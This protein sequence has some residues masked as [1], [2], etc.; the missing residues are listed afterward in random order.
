MSIQLCSL[1]YEHPD[2]TKIFGPLNLSLD[3][4][5]K[6]GLVGPNGVGKST[7]ARIIAGELEPTDGLC[8]SDL[9]VAHFPQEEAP[10]ESCRHLS[11]GEW[12]KRRLEE[13][14]SDCSDFMVFDE[15]TN[16]L[17]RQGRLD[18]LEFVKSFEGGLLIISH[19]RELLEA[20]DVILELSNR[21]LAR[22]GG[23]WSFYEEQSRLERARLAAKLERSRRSTL[24]SKS[25][26]AEM[27]ARQEKRS[28]HGKARAERQDDSKEIISGLKRK[29]QLT[30]SRLD[31][32]TS[33][34][35]ADSD[36]NF[37]ES[38]A[39]LKSKPQIYADFPETEIPAS[40]LVLLAENLNFKFAGEP[41]PLWGAP[42]SLTVKGPMKV[43]I[44]G[45]NGAGKSTFLRLLIGDPESPGE[46]SGTV[47]LGNLNF[48]FI[49]QS[50]AIVDRAKSVLEN[51]RS[52]SQKD[53]G[54]LRNLLAQ[55]LFTGDKVHQTAGTLSGGEK[56]RLAFAIS[57]LAD[58]AP[59]ILILDEPTNNID[60]TNL[61]FIEAALEKFKGA[62]FVV[63]HDMTFLENIGIDLWIDL[64]NIKM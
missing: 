8:R 21:G 29:A 35:H 4:G 47:Q 45:G 30:V 52:K 19:D 13:I 56:L 23:N 42:I 63:S 17:D 9:V 16:N 18:F 40:K 49:D 64:E 61:E 24:K 5:T 41:A 59:Q 26:R 39:A 11:G 31:K 36:L 27:L 14:L 3:R 55:F 10:P 51:T 28:R 6:Y 1:S 60:I 53:Q 43:A 46:Q 20:V 38:L 33:E 7:L 22:F 37:R 57:L 25:H 15:P 50:L 44:T 62:L 34:A 58:P 48:R 12:A 2:G 54:E 32:R